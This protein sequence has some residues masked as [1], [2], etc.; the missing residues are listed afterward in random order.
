MQWTPKTL[1]S[2]GQQVRFTVHRNGRHVGTTV[3]TVE[4]AFGWADAGYQVVMA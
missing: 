2:S 1:P 4:D 3:G